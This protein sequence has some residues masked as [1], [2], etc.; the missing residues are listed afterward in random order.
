MCWRRLPS[1]PVTL[2]AGG[3]RV[4]IDD[5]GEGPGAAVVGD[6][7]PN[8]RLSLDVA[9]LGGKKRLR[10][11]TLPSPPGELLYRFATVNDIHIGDRAF[12][13]Y[14]GMA[15]PPGTEPPFP[16]R[17]ATAALQEAVEWGAE[18]IVVKGDLTR[19][20]RPREWASV[21]RLLA[22][23][24]IPVDIIL[25]NHDVQRTAPDARPLL[26]EH[27]IK[28][29]IEPFFRDV[30]GLR[31]V[32]G[33]TAAQGARKG[34]IDEAQRRAVA[35]LCAAADGPAFVALHHYLQR[36]RM[37]TMWPP[38]VP[39]PQA[40]AFLDAIEAANPATIVATGHSHRHRRHSRHAIVT[41]EIGSTKDY[42]GTWAGYA[43]HEG[44]IRQ[45]VRR[46]AA[47]EAIAWTDRTRWALLGIWGLYSPGPLSHRC[48]TH[49]WL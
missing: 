30:P 49:P 12:G 23:Q 32:F 33:H 5:A 2:A 20:G 43:V 48:F 38:G 7:P 31:L 18:S 45:V 21:G 1:G 24:P 11:K 16:W 26:A 17:C 3:T 36:F 22:S 15:E 27:G 6:L 9:W 25:G 47:P 42:P 35:E 14:R 34:A 19:A 41:A 37:T 13:M 28:V 4:E 46:V 29:P 40:D 8:S 44:G 39:G 10:F